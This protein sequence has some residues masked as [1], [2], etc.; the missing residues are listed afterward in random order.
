MGL[1]VTRLQNRG[2]ND[3]DVNMEAADP[4][5]SLH[6][7]GLPKES[8][9]GPQKAQ[10]TTKKAQRQLQKVFLVHFESSYVLF[11][12]LLLSRRSSGHHFLAG[13]RRCFV[14]AL[15]DNGNHFRT[16]FKSENVVPNLK[17]QMELR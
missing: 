9:N 10:K 11:C 1:G 14:D 2:I 3:Q 17:V 13:T 4:F 6:H 16:F 8:E 15:H 7:R 12:G 5:R